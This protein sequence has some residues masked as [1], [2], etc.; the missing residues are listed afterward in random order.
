MSCVI[1]IATPKFATIV[2]DGR[3]INI[4]TGEIISENYQKVIRIR[5]D[6]IA[7]FTGTEQVSRRAFDDLPDDVSVLSFFDISKI[8]CAGAKKR[9]EDTGLKGSIILAGIEGSRI[10][11]YRF[12]RRNS[13]EL[14][15][16]EPEFTE[17]LGLYPDEITHDILYECYMEYY[18]TGNLQ[19]VIRETFRRVA[20]LSDFVNQSL[21]Q[22]TVEIP[23][24]AAPSLLSLF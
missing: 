24:K 3:A 15:R 19:K 1:C 18:T 9:H 4:D 14:E 5:N 8:L 13:Y 16:I 21:I 17:L 7:G 11:I 2:G 6:V 23:R 12:S 10:V 20:S 22:L